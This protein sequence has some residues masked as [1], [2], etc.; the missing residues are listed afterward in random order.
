MA[1]SGN[2]ANTFLIHNF[3]GGHD[4]DGRILVERFKVLGSGDIRPVPNGATDAKGR[5]R[6][7]RTVVLRK[8]AEAMRPDRTEMIICT[9]LLTRGRRD[10]DALPSRHVDGTRLNLKVSTLSRLHMASANLAI[11]ADQ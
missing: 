9:D 8:E 6:S 3:G 5:Q 1:I 2:T 4:G 10:E 11:T 7:G